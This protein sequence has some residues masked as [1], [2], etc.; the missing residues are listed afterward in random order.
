MVTTF[1]CGPCRS[2]RVTSTLTVGRVAQIATRWLP[3]LL[4]YLA[5]HCWFSPIGECSPFLLCLAV[6][7]RCLLDDSRLL[8][9][10]LRPSALVCCGEAGICARSLAWSSFSFSSIGSARDGMCPVVSSSQ[11]K[12]S[13]QALMKFEGP[14]IT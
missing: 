11:R 10:T 6:P 1:A 2:V 12:M 9:V 5:A 13:L 8:G 14:A 3:E 7:T 4:C